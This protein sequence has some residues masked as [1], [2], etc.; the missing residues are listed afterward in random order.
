MRRFASATVSAVEAHFNH[1]RTEWESV[2]D[3]KDGDVIQFYLEEPDGESQGFLYHAFFDPGDPP[4]MYGGVDEVPTE[5]LNPEDL[6][7]Y[8]N[9]TPAE[10]SVDFLARYFDE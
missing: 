5:W 8:F 2:I 6:K 3:L 1:P 4:V 9:T 10:F 7:F